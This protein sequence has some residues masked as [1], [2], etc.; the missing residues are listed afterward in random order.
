MTGTDRLPSHIKC[1]VAQQFSQQIL[2]FENFKLRF[3]SVL[4]CYTNTLVASVVI[5]CLF[6]F[7]SYRRIFCRKKN[8]QPRQ[9]LRSNFNNHQNQLCTET[10]EP[11]YRAIIKLSINRRG[12]N[13]MGKQKVKE[14]DKK[15]NIYLHCSNTVQRELKNHFK[16]FNLQ[17][18]SGPSTHS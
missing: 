2:L 5:K 9:T 3:I 18:N 14:E 4:S 13:P 10:E 16:Y 15:N 11:V 7:T 12:S 1:S 17:S 6:K 8:R